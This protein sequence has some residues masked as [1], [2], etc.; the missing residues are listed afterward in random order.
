MKVILIF[1]MV[2]VLFTFF[3]RSDDE[4]QEE[5]WGGFTDD[6]ES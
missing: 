5:E 6:T 2:L 3:D 1:L 4:P